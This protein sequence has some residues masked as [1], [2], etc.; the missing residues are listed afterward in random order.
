MPPTSLREMPPPPVFCVDPSDKKIRFYVV[1]LSL[2]CIVKMVI[3]LHISPRV[4]LIQPPPPKNPWFRQCLKS[5]SA[6]SSAILN[7]ICSNLRASNYSGQPAEGKM[8]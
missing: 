8:E 5:L 3:K 2:I 7:A 1:L 6:S 4:T